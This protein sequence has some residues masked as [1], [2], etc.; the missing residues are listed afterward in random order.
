EL[1]PEFALSL[2]QAQL[3]LG[4]FVDAERHAQIAM[5]TNPRA[6]KLV[7]AQTRAARRDFASALAILDELQ[8]PPQPPRYWFVRGD[9][10][11]RMNRLPEAREAFERA[12][13]VDPQHVDAYVAFA[14]VQRISGDVAASDA[15]LAKMVAA[16]PET[17]EL[18][19][20][21]RREWAR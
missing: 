7:V 21:R 9:V 18:A 5:R 8:A 17:R 16:N 1:A 4:K 11:A 14:L 13:A 2:A 6:A 3:A 15:T 12:I 20:R 10:L 19:E